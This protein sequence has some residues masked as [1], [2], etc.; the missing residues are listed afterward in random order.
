MQKTIL[1]SMFLFA[2]RQGLNL[3][4]HCYVK[5]RC[6]RWMYFIGKWRANLYMENC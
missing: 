2:S 5:E 1:Q 4:F 3:V 6:K